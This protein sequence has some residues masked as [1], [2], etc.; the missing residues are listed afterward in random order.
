[1]RGRAAKGE[2]E[3]SNAQLFGLNGRPHETPPQKGRSE[4]MSCVSIPAFSDSQRENRPVAV[5]GHLLLLP[6]E[7]MRTIPIKS[8]RTIAVVAK[9][10]QDGGEIVQKL[11]DITQEMLQTTVAR[12]QAEEAAKAA[13]VATTTPASVPAAFDLQRQGPRDHPAADESDYGAGFPQGRQLCPCR[14]SAG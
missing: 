6:F 2:E 1:M 10:A 5:L 8:Q 12:I 9:Y 3:R 4:R 7:S 14:D 13:D 11:G